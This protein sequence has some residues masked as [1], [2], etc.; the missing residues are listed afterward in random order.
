MT[1]AQVQIAQR[2]RPLGGAL[3]VWL[4]FRLVPFLGAHLIKLLTYTLRIRRVDLEPVEDLVAQGERIILA[5]YHRRLMMMSQAYVFRR[6]DSGE[7]PRGVA[8]LSS[9]S[10]DGERSA[11][12]WR[13]FGIHAVRGTAGS[14]RGAQALVKLIRIVKEGWDLG[15][16]VDGP[17]GPRQQVKGGVLSV[18]RKTGAWV[19]PVCVAYGDAWKLGT[20]D[21]MLVPKPFS[22]VVVRYG[23]P[24]RVSPQEDEEPHRLALQEELDALEA[25]SAQGAA[26]K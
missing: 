23:K 4:Q 20:W 26:V 17:R 12:A 7:E 11:A 13:W 1:G 5:F 10:K 8:I 19:V 14:L 18:S 25:W 15:I 9:D 2:G 6:F 21:E 24:F 16:T 22:R 3:A